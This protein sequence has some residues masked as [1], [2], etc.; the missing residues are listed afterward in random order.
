MDDLA[1]RL[2]W[3]P[4]VNRYWRRHPQGRGMFLT[5]EGRAYRSAAEHAK[6]HSPITGPVRVAIDLILPD[7]RR[8]DIDNVLKPILDA[9]GHAGI[10]ED[11]SQVVSLVV[12]KRHVE[13]PGCVDIIISEVS[14]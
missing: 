3:P 11:D 4:S 10:Y 8:R 14:R 2:D 7:R 13:P 9:I 6:P 1:I 5:N 12:E